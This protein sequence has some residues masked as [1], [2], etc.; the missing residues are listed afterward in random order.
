M[1]IKFELIFIFVL[2]LCNFCKNKKIL[3]GKKTIIIGTEAG[4]YGKDQIERILK[5][6]Y[7]NID[8]VYENSDRADLIIRGPFP[9]EE[10]YWN[11][12]KLPYI[13]KTHETYLPEKSEYA[14]S[15][16]FIGII[17]NRHNLQKY[18]NNKNMLKE[19]D[20]YIHFPGIYK[21]YYFKNKHK[22]KTKSYFLGY[23][24]RNPVSER[25]DLYNKFVEKTKNT[26]KKCIAL[27]KN[28]GKYPQ[29][30]YNY[31]NTDKISTNRFRVKQDKKLELFGKCNFIFAMENTNDVSPSEKIFEVFKSNS[32]PIFWGQN[33]DMFNKKAYINVNDFKNFD[34]CVDYVLNMTEKQIEIMLNEY[35]FNKNNDYVN[36]WN[37]NLNNKTLKNDCNLIKSLIENKKLNGGNNKFKLHNNLGTPSNFDEPVDFLIPWS[38]I[39]HSHI[40]DSL[41]QDKHRFSYNNEL[42]YCILCIINNASWYNN[43][44]IYLDKKEDLY[45]IIN[46]DLCKK[47]RII[48]VYRGKYFKKE[49]YPTMNICAIETTFHKIKELGEYFIYID[50]DIFITNKVEKGHFFSNDNKPIIMYSRIHSKS[51]VYFKD[52]K[53]HRIYINESVFKGKTPLSFGVHTHICNGYKKSLLQNFAKKYNDWYDFVQSHKTRYSSDNSDNMWRLEEYMKGIWNY[54]LYKNNK[55]IIRLL[56]SNSVNILIEYP[57]FNDKK[58]LYKIVKN[59]KTKFVNFNDCKLVTPEE[60]FHKMKEVT[61]DLQIKII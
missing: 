55:G 1:I 52:R 53:P 4:V 10:P 3:G 42:Y 24:Y 20:V 5:K 32:I 35:P 15:H 28:H 29:T 7:K 49:N 25:E 8:I 57:W 44:I 46:K 33:C 56:D 50:D 18:K 48:P 43:I 40:D 12:K 38:G 17:P 16:L 31:E 58:N 37:N 45:S 54:D 11:K 30:L 6:I 13:Y 21:N 61:K 59:N 27:G 9:N 26:N 34:E 51:P 36:Y 2:F 39:S 60:S 47:Y 22:K 23:C 14:T 19:N 41:K